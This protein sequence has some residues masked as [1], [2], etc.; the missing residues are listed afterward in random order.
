MFV[1]CVVVF[2]LGGFP[3]LLEVI[4]PF[5]WQSKEQ[6]LP[7]SIPE[8]VFEEVIFEKYCKV[9]PSH[10]MAIKLRLPVESAS[11]TQIKPFSWKKARMLS[12]LFKRP[13]RTSDQC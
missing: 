5:I 1:A 12:F 8:L 11:W 9:T 3:L 4:F 13:Q 2:R 10:N 6:C 7:S